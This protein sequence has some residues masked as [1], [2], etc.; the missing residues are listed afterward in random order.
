VERERGRKGEGEKGRKGEGEKG[1]LHQMQGMY[2]DIV[3]LAKV[4]S[5]VLARALPHAHK[6]T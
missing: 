5:D 3:V 1:R 2:R 4:L 6:F